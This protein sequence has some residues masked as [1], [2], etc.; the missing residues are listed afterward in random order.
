MTRIV[1]LAILFSLS[2]ILLACHST[3]Q[4]AGT[5]H[6]KFAEM[7][8]FGTTIR[9]RPDST[10]QYVFQGDLMYDSTTGH[11]QVRGNKVFVTF[12]PEH[13]DSTKLYYRFDNMPLR[14]TIFDGTP[15]K[16]KLLW[17][18]GRDKLFAAYA[19]TNKKITRAKRYNKRRKY[20]LFGSHYR[21][22][23]F[24]YRRVG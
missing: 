17:Y 21:Q 16:Y 10:L 7:M 19:E 15:F 8:M 1:K 14:T 23:R 3:R 22:A 13:H 9:L 12:D 4:V 6:S 24:Y 20:I 18:I 11:Y 5:Y 2:F